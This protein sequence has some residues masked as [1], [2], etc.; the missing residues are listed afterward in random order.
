[1]Q[2]TKVYTPIE[3]LPM[4]GIPKGTPSTADQYIRNMR[5]DGLLRTSKK[6]GQ[7]WAITEEDIIYVREQIGEGKYI[8]SSRHIKKVA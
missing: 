3:A 4:M 2:L 6:V 7:F 8:P 5:D 1:M